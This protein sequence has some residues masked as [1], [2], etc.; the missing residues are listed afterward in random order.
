MKIKVRSLIIAAVVL[1]GLIV[2]GFILRA[3]QLKRREFQRV[4][5]IFNEVSDC[6]GANTENPK[7][8]R[9][10]FIECYISEDP[11]GCFEKVFSMFPEHIHRRCLETFYYKG[12]FKRK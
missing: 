1:A 3:E 6:Y 8:V 5:R 2:G 11:D 12:V 10:V 7:L 4:E 9:R